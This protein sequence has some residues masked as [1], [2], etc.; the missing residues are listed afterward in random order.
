MGD[1]IFVTF[2][3][4]AEMSPKSVNIREHLHAIPQM[5]CGLITHLGNVQHDVK[6]NFKG[7][8]VEH[9][10]GATLNGKHWIIGGYKKRQVFAKKS[11]RY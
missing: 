1:V 7:R 9:S 3:D 2:V 8:A 4:V 10:C 5:I 6:L 11:L